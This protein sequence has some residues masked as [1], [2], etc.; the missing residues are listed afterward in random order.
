M[1]TNQELPNP[2]IPSETPNSRF[3]ADLRAA[4][5]LIQA[6]PDIFP[7]PLEINISQFH[8]GKQGREIIARAMRTLGKCEKGLQENRFIL[9]THIGKNIIIR[10]WADREVICERVVTKRVVPACI[11]ASQPATEE[12]IIPEHEEEIVTWSCPESIL[13]EGGAL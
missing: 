3:V 9:K 2:E 6:N 10:L 12:R 8:S 13:A 4:A 5:D 7:R 1:S 11:I